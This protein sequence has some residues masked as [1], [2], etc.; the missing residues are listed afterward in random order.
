MSK[1]SMVPH[2]MVP[3]SMILY[4]TFLF[5][6]LT[7]GV[8]FTYAKKRNIYGIA[9]MHSILFAL[10]LQLTYK[11]IL[12]LTT[13]EGFTEGATTLTSEKKKA[14]KSILEDWQNKNKEPLTQLKQ[15][16]LPYIR[17]INDLEI[18]DINVDI[19]SASSSTG[20]IKIANAI[21]TAAYT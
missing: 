8:L 4:G 1:P 14:L 11:Y 18:P 19:I 12:R 21:Y 16:S 17:K 20:I 6:L 10:V 3:H 9:L 15:N 2:S 5:F 7:P 13:K